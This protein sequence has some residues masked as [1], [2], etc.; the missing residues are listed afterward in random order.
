M[1]HLYDMLSAGNTL[2]YIH[3]LLNP[4]AGYCLVFLSKQIY[5]IQNKWINT[6]FE[7]LMTSWLY[8]LSAWYGCQSHFYAAVDL[9]TN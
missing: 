6:Y 7:Y 4:Y 5:Q 2:R 9:W 1:L 8:H 3:I